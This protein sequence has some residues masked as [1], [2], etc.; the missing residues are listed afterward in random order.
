M[1]KLLSIFLL[2]LMCVQLLPIEQMGK[3]LFNNQIVEEHVD[4][5]CSSSKNLKLNSGDI[6]CHRYGDLDVELNPELFANALS[7]RYHEDIPASPVQ[8]IQT[9]PPNSHVA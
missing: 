8:E 4:G 9:P 6:N 7:F 3:L 2:G 5:G 1:K